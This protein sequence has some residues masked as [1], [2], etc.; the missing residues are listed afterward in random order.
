MPTTTTAK[1]LAFATG[2]ALGLAIGVPAGGWISEAHAAPI[3][4]DDP[5]WDCRTMG[6]LV[7]GPAN[8]NG[9]APGQY[10]GGA[11][12]KAWPTATVC[13]HPVTVP[14]MIMGTTGCH[15]E[16]LAPVVVRALGVFA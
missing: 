7:C 5:A 10:A 2:L 12:V 3:T 14:N 4:E 11:L 6:D 9:V 13:P 1:R 8:G 16:F 15:A